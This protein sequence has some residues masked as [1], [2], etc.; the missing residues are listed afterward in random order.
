MDEIKEEIELLE[1][2]DELIATM[3]ENNEEDDD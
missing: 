2:L 3:E 1:E